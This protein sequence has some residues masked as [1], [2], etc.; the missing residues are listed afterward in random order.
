MLCD[1][2]YH[3]DACIALVTREQKRHAE[4]EANKRTSLHLLVRVLS[5]ARD[6]LHGSLVRGVNVFPKDTRTIF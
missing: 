6:L 1:P 4:Q 5:T 2:T 3:Q